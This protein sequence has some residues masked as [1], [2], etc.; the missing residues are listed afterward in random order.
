M[1]RYKERVCVCVCV[2]VCVRVCM[3][4]CM[5]VCA[6][7][8]VVCLCCVCIVCLCCVSVLG[9]SAVCSCFFCPSWD[10]GHVEHQDALSLIRVCVFGVCVCVCVCVCVW[11]VLM[12]PV[13][14]C[15]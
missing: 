15:V 9:V 13:G 3:R 2:C 7:V 10:Q 8:C 11:C 12:S 14:D 1:Q 5:R 6:C 4:A